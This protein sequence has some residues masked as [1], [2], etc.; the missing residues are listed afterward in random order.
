MTTTVTK[1]TVR[2]IDSGSH[3]VGAGIAAV[4]LLIVLLIEY[5]IFP[6]MGATA[7]AR[8]ARVYLPTI[9]PLLVAFV[10]VVIA[11]LVDELSSH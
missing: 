3:A 11:R 10:V 5:Q 2:A 9:A 8:R 7:A 1:L 4:I 6:M